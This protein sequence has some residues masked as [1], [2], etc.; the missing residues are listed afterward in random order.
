MARFDGCP[1]RRPPVK[2]PEANGFELS[3]AF[4]VANDGTVLE[5]S[6]AI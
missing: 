5:K 4:S 6:P 1:C 3:M 2:E